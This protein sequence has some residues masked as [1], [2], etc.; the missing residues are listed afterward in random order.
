MAALLQARSETMWLFGASVSKLARATIFMSRILSP[1]RSLG[2]NVQCVLTGVAASH[3]MCTLT[4]LQGP[5]RRSP[6]A[7]YIAF[8]AQGHSCSTR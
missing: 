2:G 3:H 6:K 8:P 4:D 7:R 5:P 1:D